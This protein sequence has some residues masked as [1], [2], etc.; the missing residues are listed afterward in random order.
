MLG[1]RAVTYLAFV[2][3]PAATAAVQ[4]ILRSNQD[5]YRSPGIH[6]LVHNASEVDTL[7]LSSITSDEYNTL[8]HTRFP[9]HQVRVKKTQFCDPTVK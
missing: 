8:S 9:H 6:G 1:S 2:F 5:F 7:H 4:D 3:L